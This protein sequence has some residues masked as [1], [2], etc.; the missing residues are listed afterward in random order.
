MVCGY[1]FGNSVLQ[2]R[3][4]LE[5]RIRDQLRMGCERLGLTLTYDTDIAVEFE[6]L[7]R[8]V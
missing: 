7:I 4:E 2:S 6:Q 1:S 3:Q 5:V 8:Q